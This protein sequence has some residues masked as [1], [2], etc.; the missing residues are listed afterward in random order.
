MEDAP[1]ERPAGRSRLDSVDLL[2]GVAMVLMAL[3]HTR[4]YFHCSGTYFNF[5]PTDLSRTWPALFLTRWVT[6]FCAPIFVFLAGTGAFLSAS[7]G[8]T[9]P[10]L[11]KF[12][13][14]RGLF[15]VVLEMTVMHVAWWFNFNL[16]AQPVQVIWCL[17]WCMIA[18]SALIYLPLWAI[19][20]FGVAMIGVHNLFDGVHAQN[21]GAFGWLWQVLH[22]GGLFLPSQYCGFFF[23]YPLI[24]WIGVMAVGYGFG[25]LLLLE[26]GARR[27]WMLALG[28]ALVLLFVAL[29]ALNR[30][31]DPTPWSAQKSGLFT[32]FSFINTF[33]YPPSLLYLLMTLG[34]AVMA[35]ALFDR[36]PGWLGRR[37]IVFGRVPLFFYII[38]IYLIHALAVAFAFARYG[39]AK[40]LFMLPDLPPPPVP[41]DYGYGLPVVYLIWIGV[42]LVLYPLCVWYAGVK[43]R[44]RSPWLSYL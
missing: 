42:V 23:A 13:L 44:R 29:R 25:R 7:R 10:E 21:L 4:D 36:A 8:K 3:D 6:H 16:L 41:K 12:L 26:R 32:F 40:W 5:D 22:E 24:P 33:K 11:S 2:R 38:H 27:R 37:L 18:L 39:Q 19:T 9:K 43:K 17:G 31:G 34:P 35:L 1:G 20:A 28:I 14:K 30:Y 15:L